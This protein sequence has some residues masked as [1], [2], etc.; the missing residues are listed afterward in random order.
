MN[1]LRSFKTSINVINTCSSKFI[2]T[3]KALTLHT[4]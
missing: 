2:A 3:A 4:Y 1:C